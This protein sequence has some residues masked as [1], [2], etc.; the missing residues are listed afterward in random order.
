MKTAQQLGVAVFCSKEI[1]TEK[2][3]RDWV[4]V[5]PDY[6]DEGLGVTSFS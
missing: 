2:N 3:V 1:T 4:W 5:L 6:C